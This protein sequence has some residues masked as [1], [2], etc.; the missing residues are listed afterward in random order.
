MFTCA[1]FVET[2]NETIFFENSYD[3]GKKNCE[4][5]VNCGGCRCV[6][7]GCL[8]NI[9]QWFSIYL[10]LE[11]KI[12]DKGYSV[13]YCLFL[14]HLLTPL[15]SR[16]NS[17]FNWQQFHKPDWRLGHVLSSW[18][19]FESRIDF[20]WVAR[21]STLVFH[22]TVANREGTSIGGF[23]SVHKSHCSCFCS[24][25]DIYFKRLWNEP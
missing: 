2:K 13:D 17:N 18:E 23:L 21:V 19:G 24:W 14:I 4:V 7:I 15:N 22:T 11:T 1:C 9:V 8:S 6:F 25:F 5:F 3:C 16:T 12:M 10:F 20:Q